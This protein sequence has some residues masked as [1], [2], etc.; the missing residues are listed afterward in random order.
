[1][2]GEKSQTETDPTP[3]PTGNGDPIHRQSLTRPRDDRNPEAARCVDGDEHDQ[4]DGDLEDG[5]AGNGDNAVDTGIQKPKKPSA[6]Q[7]VITKLGLD[8]PTLLMMFKGSIPPTIG[9]VIYQSNAVASYFGSFGYLVPI[10]TVFGLAVLPRGKFM[11][12][13]VLNVLLIGLGAALSMLAL[14]SAIQARYNTTPA[15]VDPRL[16]GYNSSQS[17]VCGVWLFASI[18]LSNTLRAK[19]PSFNLPVIIFSILLNVAT[20]YGAVLTSLEAAE[21][22]I[23]QLV[24]AMLA[25]LAIALGVNLL[26]VPVS[27]RQVLTREL[28]A[29]VSLLR[30]TVSLQ[31]AYLVRLESD[32]MFSMASRTE[33]QLS[34]WDKA[35]KRNKPKLT[36]EARAAKALHESVAKLKEMAG[37]LHADAPF[38]KR[39]I[40]WGKLDAKDLSKIISL[41]R[42]LYIPVLGMTTI[43]DIFKRISERRGWVVDDSMPPE[44][45]AEKEIE[46]RVWNSVMRQMRDPFEILSEAIDQGLE[47]AVICLEIVPRPKP[48]PGK[49]VEAQ[50]GKLQPGDPGFAQAIDRKIKA[51]NLRRG[52]LLRAWVGERE[53]ALQEERIDNPGYKYSAARLER[54]QVQFYILLF[55]ENLMHTAGI[56]VHELTAFAD[57]KVEDG[58]MKKSRLILPGFRRLKKWFI[59]IVSN[60]DS[61]AEQSP[62]LMEGTPNIIY[63]GDGYNRKKDP[64]HLP[65]AT[66]WQRFGQLLRSLSKF[67]GS[68]ESAF[69]F[70]AACA[71]MTIGIVAFLESSQRFFV[72]QRLVWAMIMVA[73]GMTMTAGQSFFGFLCRVGG[74]VIAMCTSLVIWYMV[75]ERTPGAIVFIW[76][77]TFIDMYF[78]IKYPRFIPAIMIM[79]VTQI[80]IVGYELQVM[81][82]GREA[83]ERSGQPYYPTYQL[84]PYRLACVAG[85]SLVAFLWTIFPSPLTDR[86]WLRRDLSAT[87]YLVA[88]YFSIVNSTLQSQLDHTEGDSS[89][90]ASPAH[91]LL[92]LRH[93]I[94]GKVMLLLPSLSQHSYWEKWEPT[95]GG[96][97]PRE[98]YDEIILRSTRIM[99]YLTLMA[100]TLTH[101]VRLHPGKPADGDKKED[102]V[103][104][105]TPEEGGTS[106][107]VPPSRAGSTVPHHERA[108][109]DALADV[110][111]SLS[112][113]NHTIL[114][115]LTLLSN[116][117]LSGQSLP[118]FLP[119]PRPYEMTRRLMRL[120][121]QHHHHHRRHVSVPGSLPDYDSESSSDTGLPR[122]KILNT[123]TGADDERDV[124][125]RMRS[126]A[127]SAAGSYINTHDLLDP[128][129]MEQPGYAEFA[130]LQVCSTLVCDD[131]E[132]LVKAVS[133]LVGV[134]DFSFRVSGA[135]SSSGSGSATSMSEAGRE[136]GKGKVD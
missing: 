115:T 1:M 87:L 67:F 36:K 128:R 105:E 124:L 13:L 8:V 122:I 80:L 73:I 18:W 60:E 103:A 54:D 22:F 110:F 6:L 79:I 27:S 12:S 50:A 95:V 51:F 135:G 78:F 72:E 84:A 3:S 43:T 113:T 20:T 93:K 66:A 58:T 32:D 119:L 47:H 91:Q 109:I 21:V 112:P 107:R 83:S 111:D 102:C 76:L 39:D 130:A 7:K 101:P 46:K 104:G 26:V 77:F 136:K 34:N 99:G 98:A 38:A 82:V 126:G 117:L 44:V 121:Q 118:P 63:F 108:W 62:D 49:D 89:D 127:G 100:Y 23:Q 75:A 10:I 96:K 71:T 45:L 40:A 9:I 2:E 64:E 81:K 16:P 4:Y 55:M 35:A 116:S 28:G 133:G 70:R 125:E 65:P 114:S 33:T 41:Y 74:T 59:G 17:A 85:G 90:P 69:G 30:K 88:N 120:G 15:G 48:R 52:E 53:A 25:A 131:L 106:S 29:C 68:E 5:N 134:V 57:S 123:E 132:R 37:K 61:S 19:L 92:K 42:N 24:T 97:Y 94:Y 56:A 86:T 129:N 11:M 31:K 14:W